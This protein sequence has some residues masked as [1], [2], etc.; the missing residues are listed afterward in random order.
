VIVDRVGIRTTFTGAGL[1]CLVFSLLLLRW[2]RHIRLRE[3][4]PD[5]RERV[6]TAVAVGTLIEEEA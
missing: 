1:V 5:E 6:D 2:G 3:E 4:P